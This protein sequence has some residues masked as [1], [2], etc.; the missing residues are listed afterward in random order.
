MTSTTTDNVSAQDAL[1][2]AEATYRSTQDAVDRARAAA[3]RQELDA[4]EAAAAQAIA[5]AVTGEGDRATADAARERVEQ[6]RRDH[7][8]AAVELQAAE[9]AMSRAAEDA[10]RANRAVVA[11]EYVSAHK[12]HNDPKTRVNQLLE[13]LPA[14]LAELNPLVEARNELHRRLGQEFSHLPIGERPTLPPGQPLTAPDAGAMPL[15]M[16]QVPR[17]AIADA[18]EAGI[19]AARQ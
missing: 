6:L 19:A 16:V 10:A 8:W 13:Q 4:A 1:D 7:E 18:I 11:Q 17:G 2:V 12:T 3:S 5:A 15:V 14:L 9:T